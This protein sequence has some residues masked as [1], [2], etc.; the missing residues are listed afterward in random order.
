M[1]E[2]GSITT[3]KIEDLVKSAPTDR[4]AIVDLIQAM[5][6]AGFGLTL[7]IFS[8][9]IIIPLPPPFPSMIAIPLAIFSFQMMIGL[10]APKLPKMFA[11]MTVKRSILGALVRKSSPYIGKVEKILR[12]RLIFMTSMIA[13]RIVGGLIFMFSVFVLAPLPLSN[14]I[15]GLGVLITSFGMIGRDGLVMILGI[16]VGFL[17][18]A[19]AVLTVFFGL[20]ALNYIKTLFFS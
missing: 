18:M 10:P 4:V 16:L 17:G 7:M 15:P 11:K 13:E 14:F 8:F 12:P 1:Q 19:I 5:E 2:K 3:H 20:E 9:G 6:G